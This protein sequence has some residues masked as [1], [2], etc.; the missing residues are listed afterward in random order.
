MKIV[1]VGMTGQ[2]HENW[3]VWFPLLGFKTQYFQKVFIMSLFTLPI[4]FKT[5]MIL[6]YKTKQS[7]SLNL[8]M[9]TTWQI[10]SIAN[11]TKP[12]WVA[13]NKEEIR[14]WKQPGWWEHDDGRRLMAGKPSWSRRKV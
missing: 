4:L 1:P 2:L 9:E 12:F 8:N 6:L 3:D 13:T 10:T 14:K 7:F 5:Q 11:K